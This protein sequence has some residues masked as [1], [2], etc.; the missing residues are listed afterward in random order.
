MRPMGPVGAM[1]PW[2]LWDP[3]EMPMG[4]MDPMDQTRQDINLPS[5]SFLADST[6]PEQPGLEAGRL[7]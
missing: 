5:F 1:G 7:Q 4:A 2:D 6:V 3:W